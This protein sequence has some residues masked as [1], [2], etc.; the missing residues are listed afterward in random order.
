[1]IKINLFVQWDG[2][3]CFLSVTSQL[4]LHFQLEER[5]FCKDLLDLT[6]IILTGDKVYKIKYR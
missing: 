2:E 1:M 4:H 6:K 5:K 3:L